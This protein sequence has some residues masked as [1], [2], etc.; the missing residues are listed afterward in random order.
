MCRGPVVPGSSYKC[1]AQ[2][3]LLILPEAMHLT[4]RGV[5][6]NAIHW[7]RQPYEVL[8]LHLNKYSSFTLRI[9]VQNTN[10]YNHVFTKAGK[11]SNVRSLVVN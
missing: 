11:I 9:H 8:T 6:V 7:Q 2:V 3:A 1:Q 10:M 5:V 4:S